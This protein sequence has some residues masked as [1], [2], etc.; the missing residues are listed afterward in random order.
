MVSM[1]R[2]EKKRSLLS[3]VNLRSK[4]TGIVSIVSIA[5]IGVLT[6]VMTRAAIS[7][8][9]LEAETNAASNLV[10]NSTTASA[11]KALRFGTTDTNQNG[12]FSISGTKI[13][14]PD[15]KEFIP[16]GANV[17]GP[18]AFWDDPTIGKAATA[19][20][21]GWNTIRVTTCMPG[22]CIINGSQP[23]DISV[24]NDLDTI[25][26]QYTNQK[27]V[28]MI[29]FH[30]FSAGS[31]PSSTQLAQASTWWKD[32]ATRY[33]DNPY[34]WF[35]L[36]NEPGSLDSTLDQWNN[37]TDTLATAVR[38][39]G[40]QNIIVADGAYFGQDSRDWSCSATFPYTNSGIINRGP[41]LQAKHGNMLFSLHEYT[42]W[43]A[44]GNSCPDA[45][46]D[47]RL[48]NYVNAVRA[49][50][51]ALVVGEFSL[52][53][54]NL[55]NYQD[56]RGYAQSANAAF[57]AAPGLKLG[58]IFWHGS[59]YERSDL[60]TGSGSWVD[61]NTTASNLTPAGKKLYDFAR[62]VNPNA[63]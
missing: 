14:G 29:N 2:K 15:G 60:V 11:G 47:A 59:T 30:H 36:I 3:V 23:Y 18:H 38:S 10:I 50:N 28:T 27:I 44:E 4:K 42:W 61:I 16:V 43:G 17:N 54:D 62:I 58:L 49:K 21:W 34:V 7:S 37:V 6:L 41:T 57:R 32:T 48:V 26:A 13:I 5:L 35:N 53:P 19:K 45:T 40:A 8:A 56:M 22:G 63:Q 46:L 20:R 33:K 1:T 12:K 51:I 31:I 24:N 25:I 52:P 39:T 9:S 55:L